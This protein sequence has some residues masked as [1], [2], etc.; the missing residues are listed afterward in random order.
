MSAKKS[1]SELIAQA[2][3]DPDF[4]RRLLA[5]PEAVIA[6]EGYEVSEE[7]RQQIKDVGQRSPAALEAAILASARDGG[8]GT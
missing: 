2:I 3:R 7:A 6:A 1:Q 4:R 8:T 5:D